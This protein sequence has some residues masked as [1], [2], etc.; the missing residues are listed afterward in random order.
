MP[1]PSLEIDVVEV[2]HEET[3]DEFSKILK[4]EF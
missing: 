1:S 4:E 2:A 3:P